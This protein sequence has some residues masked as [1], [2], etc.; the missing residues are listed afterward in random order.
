MYGGARFAAAYTNTFVNNVIPG[1]AG[2][3]LPSQGCTYLTGPS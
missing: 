1:M 2:P 3:C